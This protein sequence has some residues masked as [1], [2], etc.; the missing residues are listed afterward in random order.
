MNNNHSKLLES[1]LPRLTNAAKR[2]PILDLACGNGRNGLFLIANNVPTVFADVNSA[3]L[4]TIQNMLSTAAFQSS[5]AQA[6]LWQEDF[7]LENSQALCDKQ[8]GGV[9]VFRYLH[10]PLLPRIKQAVLPGGILVYETFTVDQ[11]QYG[12]PKNPDYLLRQGE[13]QRY[14]KDW[15][16]LYSYEGVIKQSESSDSQAIAQI[17][18]LKPEQAGAQP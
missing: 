17:V 14:F 1:Y 2:G 18:A 11:P 8:F 10:R 7:E 5:K 4:K 3:A 13:L 16:I 9:L 12:R 6:E 15:N